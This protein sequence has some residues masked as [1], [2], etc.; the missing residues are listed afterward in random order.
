MHWDT[1][2]FE[3]NTKSIKRYE[4]VKVSNVQVYIETFY[5]KCKIKANKK[6]FQTVT[7]TIL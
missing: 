6:L 5:L 3:Q 7:K 4:R 1:T 2:T